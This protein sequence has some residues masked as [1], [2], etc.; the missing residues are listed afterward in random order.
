MHRRLILP[1]LLLLA[2]LLAAAPLLAAGA[3]RTLVVRGRVARADGSPAAG[4]R[5]MAKGA[6]SVSATTDDRG[7]YSLRMPMGSPE[8]LRAGA[9]RAEVRAE[10]GGRKFALASGAPALVI[11]AAFVPGTTK[12]R[13]RSNSPS[14]T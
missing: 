8:G 6:M 1:A 3:S 11:E 12:L 13:V 10:E 4:A 2:A 14:A 9:F 5:V 7:R